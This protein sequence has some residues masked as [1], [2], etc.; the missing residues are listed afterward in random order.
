MLANMCRQMRRPFFKLLQ[1]GTGNCERTVK[2]GRQALRGSECTKLS[3]TFSTTDCRRK[4]GGL[5]I[6]IAELRLQCDTT[7]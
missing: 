3:V 1:K 6:A 5:T 7:G 4:L 2:V